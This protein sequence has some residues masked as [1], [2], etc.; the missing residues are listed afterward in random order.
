MTRKNK[1]PDEVTTEYVAAHRRGVYIQTPLDNVTHFSAG[2]KY[3]TVHT[4]NAGEFIISVPIWYI[5]STLGRKL[6]TRV[7]RSHVVMNHMLPGIKMLRQ[8]NS[9]HWC[10]EILSTVTA[11]DRVGIK[12]SIVP[13]ARREGTRIR[14]VWVKA[15]A[16]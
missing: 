13:V 14:K 16:Q 6:A 7:H 4:K 12:T 1:L 10:F 3:V 15:D 11:G 2:D 8:D 9:M 5:A